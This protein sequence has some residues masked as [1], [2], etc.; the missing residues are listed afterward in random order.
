MP[1]GTAKKRGKAKVQ[2][3]FFDSMT[4]VSK[5]SAKGQ[6]VNALGFVGH[7]VTVTTKLC[8]CRIKAASHSQYTMNGLGCV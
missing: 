2:T 7:R 8:R 5:L 6:M 1:C 4:V 3:G